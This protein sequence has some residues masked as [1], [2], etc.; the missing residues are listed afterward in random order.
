MRSLMAGGG[1]AV[2]G[3]AATAFGSTT[4]TTEPNPGSAIVAF[5][6][7]LGSRDLPKSSPLPSTVQVALKQCLVFSP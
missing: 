1:G 4:G 6:A 2:V 5:L 3:N 7:S